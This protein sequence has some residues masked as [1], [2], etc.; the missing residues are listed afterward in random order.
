MIICCLMLLGWWW[1]SRGRYSVRK[2]EKD[3]H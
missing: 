1:W 2:T 3:V